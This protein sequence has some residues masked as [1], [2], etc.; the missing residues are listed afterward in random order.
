MSIIE[1]AAK[2]LEKSEPP[3]FG[4]SPLEADR[5][6][7]NEDDVLLRAFSESGK[8]SEFLEAKIAVTELDAIERTVSESGERSGRIEPREP[9][10]SSDAGDLSRALSAIPKPSVAGGKTTRM[11]RVDREHLQRQR[12][13]TPDGKRS[14]ISESFRRIKRQILANAANPRIGAPANLVMITSALEGEGKTFCAVNLAISIALEMDHTAL[15]VDADVVKPGIPRALGVKA[16]RGLID[17]L[18]GRVPLEDVLWST[19]VGKLTLLPAGSA[20]QH[21]T[22]LL[23]SEAMRG[24]LQEMARRY[25]DRVIVF[26]AP[27]LLVASEAGTLARQMG[28]I[29]VVVEAGKTSEAALKAALSHIDPDRVAGLVLN[30]G[31]APR[32]GYAYGGYG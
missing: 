8:G 9:M 31:P 10:A 25:R 7:R 32:R 26:D 23:A 29:V 1:R 21:T 4:P 13:V 24:L 2:L 6:V 11:L 17:V 20:H 22:E 19:D 30:K 27:P 16:E 5:I 14:P 3:D 15:L 28:Q 18:A 12:M